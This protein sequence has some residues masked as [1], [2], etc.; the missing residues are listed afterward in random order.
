MAPKR[1][2][3]WVEKYRPAQLSDVIFQTQAVNVME[4]IVETFNMPHLIF[5]GPP[6]T[7]KTSAALAMAR[8][9]YGLEGMKERVLELNASDERGIDVVRERIKTYTRLNI[10][11]N[12]I[13]PE[14]NRKMPNFKLIILDEAD[15]ITS[16]AQ[17]ALR[18]V[19]EAFSNISRFILICNYLHKIIGPIYSRCSAFHFRPIAPE[20]QV[21]Q[22]EF[23]CNAEGVKFESQACDYNKCRIW[24][25]LLDF[26]QAFHKEICVVQL[27]CFSLYSCITEE[28]VASV[29][30]YPPRTLAESLLDVCKRSNAEVEQLCRDIVNEG[31]DISAIFQQLCEL[32]VNHENLHDIQKAKIA[33]TLAS[34]DFAL[35][36]GGAQ[37]LQLASLC[38]FIKSTITGSR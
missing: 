37:Y 35:Y 5:H 3:P 19:I 14:T 29:S 1:N 31:W 4:Q 21:R 7:G 34:R 23:I 6:G 33:M 25:R 12:R 2:V 9:I 20:A 26:L 28:A 8:Q 32:V 13:N 11:S 36:Q 22:L 10:S 15:M 16:D 17:A 24:D 27:H 30:G 18:R 38:F